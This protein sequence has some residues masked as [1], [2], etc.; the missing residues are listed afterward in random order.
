MTTGSLTHQVLDKNPELTTKII[1][2]VARAGI[3]G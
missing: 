1:S 2:A 3:R